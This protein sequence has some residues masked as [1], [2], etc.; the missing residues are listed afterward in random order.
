MRSKLAAD[1]ESTFAEFEF[2]VRG[3]RHL[4]TRSPAWFEA[5]KK[6]AGF[7]KPEE[8][9]NLKTWGEA[10]WVTVSSRK[11]EIDARVEA[12][13]GLTQDEFAKILVLPQG[14][15]QRFLEMGTG[16]REAILEKL[17]PIKEHQRLAE[18]A[19][20]RAEEA[21]NLK[22]ELG[23]RLEEAQ[24]GAHQDT[25]QAQALEEEL[26]GAAGA[27][28]AARDQALKLRDDA[29]R[30]AQ[31][32]RRDEAAFKEQEDL[33][34]GERAYED[35]RAHREDLERERELARGAAACEPAVKAREDAG[36]ALAKAE[37]AF[38]RTGSDLE[39][40]RRER[41]ALQPDLDG[42]PERRTALMD[43]RDEQ[44]LSLKGLDDLKAFGTVWREAARAAEAFSKATEGLE[45]AEAEVSKN[46][47]GLESLEPVERDRGT[48]QEEWNGLAPLRTR[49]DRLQSD[50]DVVRAW[51]GLETKLRAAVEGAQTSARIAAERLRE[52][53][54]RVD[55]ARTLRE[56]NLAA[57]L[58][59]RLAPG[60]PCPVCGSPEHPHPALPHADL[61]PAAL[62]LEPPRVDAALTASDQK[63]RSASD[64]AISR[65]K[66]ASHRPG[67]SSWPGVSPRG[68]SRSTPPCARRP[69]TARSAWPA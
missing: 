65:L 14:D 48:L 49:L 26:R 21:R 45:A 5:K 25:A 22:A 63:A 64:L 66:E 47:Q 53:V 58:A 51:P 60:S 19:H 6:G 1:G 8:I 61:D 13:L 30:E 3:V 29:R 46:L 32:A 2:E 17:F 24:G 15:F 7:R 10:G 12:I 68:S 39:A 55:A 44:V 11:S 41:D 23:L 42:A 16:E 18:Y 59:T 36:T 28:D 40:A 35:A 34:A 20:R 57:A 38:R 50:A 4:A 62:A 67:S 37:E 54:D 56:A 52:D 31:N 9:H 27:A 33:R 69:R 43:L